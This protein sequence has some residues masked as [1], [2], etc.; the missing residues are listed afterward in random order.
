[1]VNRELALSFWSQSNIFSS[2]SNQ[3]LKNKLVLATHSVDS[4]K[5]RYY[6]YMITVFDII[7]II[8]LIIIISTVNPFLFQS[9]T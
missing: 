3:K 1:M 8:I 7:I 5:S 4:S 2:K 9:N 6:V